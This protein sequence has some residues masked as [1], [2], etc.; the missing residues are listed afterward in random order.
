MLFCMAF[1]TTQLEAL[2]R[3]VLRVLRPGGLCV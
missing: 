3:E 2:S 1:I